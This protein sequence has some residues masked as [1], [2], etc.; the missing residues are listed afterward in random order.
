[1]TEN[2]PLSKKLYWYN[3]H[4][5]EYFC[6][7]Y[8]KDID[9]FY[10]NLIKFWDHVLPGDISADLLQNGD[11]NLKV[12]ADKFLCINDRQG[13]NDFVYHMHH[14]LPDI[15]CTYHHDIANMSFTEICI[16]TAKHL[17]AKGKTID[18]F[19]SGGLDSTCVLLSLL[20]VCP[21]QIRVILNPEN[22]EYMDLFHK[23]V[24]HLEHTFIHTTEELYGT[25]KADT[26]IFTTGVQADLWFAEFFDLEYLKKMQSLTP[27]ERCLVQSTHGRYNYT[28]FDVRF[29]KHTK[30]DQININNHQPF[31]VQPLTEKFA[32]NYTLDN[33]MVFHAI[34]G[35]DEKT[36]LMETIPDYSTAKMPLRDCIAE[37][38]GDNDFAYTVRKR[39]STTY[40]FGR[41]D[42]RWPLLKY[43]N[44]YKQELA[45]I[46]LAITGEGRIIRGSNILD[47]D[48]QDF[49]NEEWY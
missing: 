9:S 39:P 19:W 38:G 40:G 7:K 22:N 28:M 2:R 43:N 23:R 24:S 4:L 33:K 18:V 1:M 41:P 35:K 42:T 48:I 37:L 46:V 13:K 36:K 44:L 30:L 25:A 29:L 15:A 32:I 26:N 27:E 3:I 47:F 20:E 12:P 21:N 16:E 11:I 31:F 45:D 49:Y 5:V 10:E 8:F 6:E 14:H 34:V 17:S